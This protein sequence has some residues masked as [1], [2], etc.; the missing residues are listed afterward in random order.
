MKLVIFRHLFKFRQTLNITFDTG[1]SS[2][3][4]R[5]Y[6]L[7]VMRP[8]E[9]RLPEGVHDNEDLLDPDHCW[10]L[11]NL[12]EFFALM[13][14]NCEN[15]ALAQEIFFKEKTF[16]L[17]PFHNTF[18]EPDIHLIHFRASKRIIGVNACRLLTRKAFLAL[19]EEEFDAA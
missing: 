16:G 5:V 1:R 8:D 12:S 19:T 7:V 3:N 13:E 17:G 4:R 6:S 18:E 9:F 11:N 2:N 15:C 14:T 10:R